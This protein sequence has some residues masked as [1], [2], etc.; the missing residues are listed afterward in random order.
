MYGRSQWPSM[1]MSGFMLSSALP[2]PG[3]CVYRAGSTMQTDD[4][5]QKA[6]LDFGKTNWST[7]QTV[8]CCT[9]FWS[10]V[11]TVCFWRIVF[12]PTVNVLR[13]AAWEY[14]MSSSPWATKWSSAKITECSF[15]ANATIKSMEISLLLQCKPSESEKFIEDGW[16]AVYPLPRE[17]IC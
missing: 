11:I 3:P 1:Y 5:N 6:E 10:T 8:N 15:R 13:F 2:P 9:Q 17:E 7:R 12:F 16:G 14:S 4:V